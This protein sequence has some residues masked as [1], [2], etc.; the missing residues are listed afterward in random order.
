MLDPIQNGICNYCN[1]I[2]FNSLPSEDEPGVPHQ[3]CFAALK[4]S[5][6]TCQLCHLLCKALDMTRDEIR[7][8]HHGRNPQ[9]ASAHKYANGKFI[10]CGR[11]GPGSYMNGL[12]TRKHDDPSSNETVKFAEDTDVQPWL[13]GNW[14]TC[15]SRDDDNVDDLRLIG[16]G[17]RLGRTPES[18]E[19]TGTGS[20]RYRGTYLR[21]RTDDSTCYNAISVGF[22]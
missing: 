10:H 22:A 19:G 1:D 13:F 2:K 17:V 20:P 5:A 7:E 9:T 4:T 8:E 3:P 11:F 12:P 14:W 6:E 18:T 15:N 16:L 21:I